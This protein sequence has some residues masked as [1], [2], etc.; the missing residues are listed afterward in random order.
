MF[1]GYSPAADAALEG[2]LA[3]MRGAGA[4]IV[5][6]ADVPHAGEYDADELEV[7]LYELKADLA[8]YF[9]TWAPGGRL[10]TLADVI[11]FNE[12]HRAEEMVWFGQELFVQAEAK[13]PLS[14][15]AY[16]RALARCRRL[17][18]REG[19]DAVL[20]RHRLDALVAPTG[21][22]AW[23]VDLVNGDHFPGASST[24]AAV[25]GYPSITV[26]AGFVHGL[27]LGLSFIGRAWSEPTLVRLASAFEH[28]TRH[29]RPPRFL[30]SLPL[31]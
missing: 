1:T 4:E 27:P 22:P 6:P 5:D 28:A 12:E 29:R 15:R 10:R 25:A 20:D 18:R 17:S 7:L 14:D 16:R 19:L 3:A 23:P 9:G 24:P 31:G 21:G 8:G 13:G 26:P 2:A 11:R 30:P